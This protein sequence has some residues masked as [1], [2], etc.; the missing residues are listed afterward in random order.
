MMVY[1]DILILFGG[2]ADNYHYND[3]WY[4]YINENRWLEKTTFVHVHYPSSCTDDIKNINANDNCIQLKPAVKPNKELYPSFKEQPWYTPDPN[5]NSLYFGIVDDAEVF[6]RRLREKF[7]NSNKTILDDEGNR[8]WI[9]S[10]IPD[11]TP[12]APYAATGSRQYAQL[13]QMKYNDTLTTPVWEWC[14]SVKG[15][16]DRNNNYNNDNNNHPS[17]L[18]ISQLRRK[19]LGWDGCR[20]NFIWKYPSSRSGHKGIFMTNYKMGF[21]YGGSGYTDNVIK[22]SI[23]ITNDKTHE[24]HVLD[25]FWMISMENCINNCSNH[26]LC[27]YGYCECDEGY[28]GIDC[29]NVTCPGSICYY[30]DKYEQ[31]CNHCCFDDEGYN[32]DDDSD[33]NSMYADSGSIYKVPCK[34]RG[35]GIFSGKSQGICDGFGSCQCASGY[36]GMCVCI[37]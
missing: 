14:T 21:I 26:G 19:S 17:F 22:N 3:T 31:H 33:D 13:K 16:P 28:Y 5:N 25:D 35:N 11:G 15:Q 36:L 4:Y 6:I 23:S 30:D 12:I 37:E 18:I 27:N 10:N 8:I 7:L 29:S 1:N 24:T 34:I 9:Q 32:N 20:D 2:Y